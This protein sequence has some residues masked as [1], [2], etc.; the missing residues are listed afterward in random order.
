MT[1]EQQRV[2]IIA[3]AKA[4]AAA[5]KANK[6]PSVGEDLLRSAGQGLRSGVEMG[7]G[8]FGDIGTGQ[9]DAARA[10]AEALGVGEEGSSA[11]ADV[12]R[13]LSFGGLGAL[14]NTDEIRSVTDDVFGEPYKPQTTGG[15]YARTG[16]EFLPA[17]L[18]PGGKGN[19]V[20]K[21]L[22]NVAI[23]A[24]SSET[25][26]Q[27]ARQ[28]APDWE[29]E[30]RIA[31]GVFGGLGGGALDRA[32]VPPGL[33]RRSQMALG[34]AL[35]GDA[36][37][38]SAA[39]ARMMELGPDAMMM[40]L[41]PNMQSRAGYVASVPGPGQGIIR[42]AV[43]ARDKGANARI[44]G[45]VDATIGPPSNPTQTKADL[46]AAKKAL[47]PLYT[48]AL[49][50]AKAVDTQGIADDLD[51]VIVN[52]RGDIQ[53]KAR[54]VRKMLD[55][56]GTDQ[57]DPNPGTLLATRQAIDDMI[58]IDTPDNL[59]AMLTR[60]RA[61]VDA[62]LSAKVPG[63]KDVDAQFADLARQGKALERGKDVLSTGKDAI[64]PSDLA[65]ELTVPSTV[66]GPSGAPLRLREGTRA[67]I[68][69]IIGT[70]ANDRLALKRVV[71]GEGDWNRAKLASLFGEEKTAQLIK[72][73][74][75]EAEFAKTSK[76]AVD[77]SESARRIAGKEDMESSGGVGV[78]DAVLAGAALGD[79]LSAGTAALVA[80]L[81][82]HLLGRNSGARIATSNAK[83]AKA[84]ISRDPGLAAALSAAPAGVGMLP[85]ALAA[86][87]L[88]SPDSARGQ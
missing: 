57:L 27:V 77:N 51:S 42:S 17:M 26:G 4:R 73:L 32:P 18:L 9:G 53:A 19:L 83:M 30:A 22:T 14:F 81:A 47:S 3:K 11:I 33:D 1:P 70:T 34:R 79:P 59:K 67:D 10:G 40:D 39:E 56:T 74:D 87:L 80:K 43:D 2:I 86:A 71:A 8:G 12:V 7:L 31:G 85:R 54:E 82:D 63:I 72:I 23:P 16:A 37:G 62:E 29:A 69:R 38:G 13:K 15:E 66:I 68:E 46:K 75:R 20:K 6:P 52:S 84:L 60:A 58:G 50:D 65:A 24:A 48:Q 41:G 44:R 36:M 21:A 5:E 76:V 78:R 45:E 88:A 61:A 64:S 35:A 49:K 28:F 55:V 25:A